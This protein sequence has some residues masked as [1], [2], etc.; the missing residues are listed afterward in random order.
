ML[1]LRNICFCIFLLRLVVQSVCERRNIVDNCTVQKMD[2]GSGTFILICTIHEE[3]HLADI[4]SVTMDKIFGRKRFT[5]EAA[6]INQNGIA[7]VFT[8]KNSKPHCS[9]PCSSTTNKPEV[10]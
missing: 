2:D 7:R 10:H 5:R 1:S 9:C 8:M 6:P 3:K 4:Q